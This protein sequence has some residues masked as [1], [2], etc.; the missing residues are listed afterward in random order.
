MIQKKHSRKQATAGAPALVE[1]FKYSLLLRHK[2]AWDGEQ[3]DKKTRSG[4]L[5]NSSICISL[6]SLLWRWSHHFHRH[7][8]AKYKGLHVLPVDAEE[9]VL[10]PEKKLTVIACAPSKKK[11][12]ISLLG[13]NQR[14]HSNTLTWPPLASLQVMAS[15]EEQV[16]HLNAY[17]DK[18]TVVQK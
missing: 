5:Q 13:R 14:C 11:Q 8:G 12:W 16:L 2:K 3:A 7:S 6:Q 1:G 17:S 4:H 10:L 15:L 18:I 9:N